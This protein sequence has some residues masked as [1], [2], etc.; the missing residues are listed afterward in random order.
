M[1]RI[2]YLGVY[3]IIVQDNRIVLIHKTR[4][5]YKGLLDLPGGGVEF[6]ETPEETLRRELREE[7]AMGSHMTHFDNLSHSATSS[8]LKDQ[9]E[10]IQFHHLGQIYWVHQPAAINVAAEDPW[11]WYPIEDLDLE[12]L[13][14]F[15]KVVVQ[16]LR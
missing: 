13:T 15:S 4:G 12:C 1:N 10:E 5:P 9:Q 6:G 2:T 3:G 11:A 14:P 16:R 8:F 7:I